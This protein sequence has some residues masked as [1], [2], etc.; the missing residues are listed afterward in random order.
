MAHE[1]PWVPFRQLYCV[2]LLVYT[3]RSCSDETITSTSRTFVC[4]TFP[5]KTSRPTLGRYLG[6]WEGGH[7]CMEGDDT[8]QLRCCLQKSQ[9]DSASSSTASPTF[10]CSSRARKCTC[11]QLAHLLMY[12]RKQGQSVE[13]PLLQEPSVPT[14]KILSCIQH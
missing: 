9:E 3:G 14:R 2:V 11:L 13:V 6:L 7:S 12:E 8:Y 5:K 1:V 4:T 10:E